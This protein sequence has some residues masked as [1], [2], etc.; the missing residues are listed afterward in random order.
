MFLSPAGLVGG[1]SLHSHLRMLALIFMHG[2][3]VGGRVVCNDSI[4]GWK[5]DG[6]HKLNTQGGD[7]WRGICMEKVYDSLSSSSRNGRDDFF[8]HFV[9]EM[10]GW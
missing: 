5:E 4:D 2:W 8:G 1:I 9:C 10:S 3:W 7:T 6:G